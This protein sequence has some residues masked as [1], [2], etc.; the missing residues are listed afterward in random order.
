MRNFRVMGPDETAS[1]R[2]SALFEVTDRVSTARIL[3]TDDHSL[4]MAA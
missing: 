4:R 3:P 1:N 2:L